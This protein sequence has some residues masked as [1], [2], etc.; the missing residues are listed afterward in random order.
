[1]GC[2]WPDHSTRFVTDTQWGSKYIDFNS[3][4]M[5]SS[6]TEKSQCLSFQGVQ[7]R[8][9]YTLKNYMHGASYQWHISHTTEC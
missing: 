8:T 4:T 6:R 2:E 1:M 3:E 9:V 7:D 5:H